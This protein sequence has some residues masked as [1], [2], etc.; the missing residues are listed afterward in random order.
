MFS[1]LVTPHE[2]VSNCKSKLVNPLSVTDVYVDVKPLSGYET[3]TCNCRPHEV[4][5]EKGCLDECLNR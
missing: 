2:S 4:S 5:A 1:L 3:T